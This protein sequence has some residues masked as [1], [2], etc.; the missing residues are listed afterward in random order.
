MTPS[1]Y[2]HG[3]FCWVDFVARD[4]TAAI[5]FYSEFFDWGV[6]TQDVVDGPP[7]AMF[8]QNGYVVAGIGGMSDEMRENGMPPTW[9][10]YVSVD[11][12]HEVTELAQDLGGTVVTPPMQFGDGWR[13]VIQDPTGG[14][15][16]L[17]QPGIHNGATLVNRPGS[18]CWNDLNTHDADSAMRFFRELF[19]W[20]FEVDTQSKG[21]YYV[22]EN[23][24]RGNGG[25]LE[26]TEELDNMPPHWMVYFNVADVDKAGARLKSLGGKV[27][28]G[29]FKT[30][31]GEMSV[32]ADPQGAS[33][34]LIQWTGP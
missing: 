13:A 10:S 3:Q 22:I 12:V 26:M 31:T 28:Q 4:V 2:T 18:F 16:G 27:H 33:F 9:N 29:P 5:E 19:G 15:L 6:E 17:W 1:S 24:G 30:P 32:V 34:Y 11:D 8:F 14:T 25:L 7:Y 20:G 21:R 23:A